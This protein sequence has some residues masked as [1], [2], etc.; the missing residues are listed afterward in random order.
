[1]LQLPIMQQLGMGPSFLLPLLPLPSPLPSDPRCLALRRRWRGMWRCGVLAGCVLLLPLRGRER[2]P[3][4]R[5]GMAR[6][7]GR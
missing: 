3:R 4:R 2:E 5:G 1:M 7:Q 6:L